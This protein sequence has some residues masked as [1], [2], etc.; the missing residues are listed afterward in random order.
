MRK[1]TSRV[2]RTNFVRF[3]LRASLHGNLYWTCPYCGSKRV[4]RMHPLTW[5]VTCPG[6]NPLH[7]KPKTFI[8]AFKFEEIPHGHSTKP[9]DWTVPDTGLMDAYSLGEVHDNWRSGMPAHKLVRAQMEDELEAVEWFVNRTWERGEDV[10]R[11]V[12]D[13]LA[14]MRAIVA[15]WTDRDAKG[16]VTAEAVRRLHAL[17]IELPP[18][19]RKAW[20]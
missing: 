12:R 8:P 1:K 9:S 20:R 6:R 4:S 15:Y 19:R 18:V 17:G 14:R 3:F 2:V 5:K 10:P 16:D 7:R 13:E 11:D